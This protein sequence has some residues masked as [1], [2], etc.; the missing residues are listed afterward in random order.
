M[1][2]GLLRAPGRREDAGGRERVRAGGGR[3][4]CYRDVLSA[5]LCAA[6]LLLYAGCATAAG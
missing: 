6:V 4:R 5:V 3:M 1:T 2:L